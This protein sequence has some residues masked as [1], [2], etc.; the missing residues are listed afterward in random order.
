MRGVL[1]ARHALA[2]GRDDGPAEIGSDRP[3]SYPL[4]VLTQRHPTIIER[5]RAAHPYGPR[6]LAALGALHAEITEGTVQPLPE[7][8]YDKAAWDTWGA[9]HFGR[10]WTATPFLWAEGYFYAKLLTAVDYWGPAP[11]TGVDPFAR[12]KAADLDSAEFAADLAALDH[13]A[14]PPATHGGSGERTAALLLGAVWGNQSDLGF[15]ISEEGRP[16]A[17]SHLLADDTARVIDALGSARRIAVLADNTGRELLADL[18][19][20]D[21][22]LCGGSVQ[23]IDLL[24]KP[25]PYFI[26][27]AILPDL[28]A[29]LDALAAGPAG[30]RTLAR[31]LDAAMRAGRLTPTT[32][33][34]CGVP[35]S[36]D[37]MPDDLRTDLAGCDLVLSKGDL[38]YRRLAGDRYWPGSTP[39]ATAVDYF[40]APV[41]AL[42]TVKSDVALG[43]PGGRLSTLDAAEPDWRVS[44]RYAMVQF[45]DRSTSAA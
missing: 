29:V 15:L 35:Y 18:V 24:L 36:Y 17:D 26:S 16:G 9:P 14:E 44:G 8:A 34:F 5:V 45:A 41:A 37:R 33:W 7:G 39:F 12:M 4:R 23:E 2:T 6:Q 42:R 22:L 11:W 21:H 27:D 38:N 30:A 10:P 1:A 40:P 25:H 28:L 3:G 43:L 32:H 20:L 31:R 13:P 19:L